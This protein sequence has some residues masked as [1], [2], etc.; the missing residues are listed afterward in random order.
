M[1]VII[2]LLLTILTWRHLPTIPFQGEGFYYF[3]KITN[4][5]ILPQD[6]L[7]QLIFYVI[8][9]I[10][11][12]RLDL[13]MYLLFIVMLV[14]DAALYVLIRVVTEN[15]LTAFVV[16][17]LFSLSYVGNYDMYSSG[18]YQYFVQRAVILLPQLLS[19]MFLIIFFLH[20]FQMRYYRL[21]LALYLLAIGMGFF[22]TWFLPPFLFYPCFYILLNLRRF[23]QIFLKIIWV[24]LPYL[25]GN[26][27]LIKDSLSPYTEEP[28]LTFLLHNPKVIPGLV[29]QL[30]V[31]SL[32]PGI[33]DWSVK[34][35]HLAERTQVVPFLGI[36]TLIF[37][38]CAAMFIWKLKP[39][40]RVL[41]VTS[42]ASI[43]LML[44][45]NLYLN[46][47][48]VLF[49]FNSS[50]YFYFPSVFIA[51]FWGLF[52][53]TLLLFL[54]KNRTYF[55]IAFCAIWLAINNIAI[56]K[57]LKDD[58]W[59][60]RANTDTINYLHLWS[61]DLKAYPSY[62]YLPANL[63][64][65]GASFVFRYFSHPDGKFRL[66]GFDELD[67]PALAKEKVDPNRLY[68]LNL[69]IKDEQVFD[70]TEESRRALRGLE[71]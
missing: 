51:I 32:P 10:F 70:K 27:L 11:N 31:I 7:A 46:S 71:R 34:S 2:L 45:F 20:N 4:K 28:F 43:V 47:A 9:P 38:L 33:Y 58:E 48:N 66:Q 64:T 59:R 37:Y 14:I 63:G 23:K 6:T 57:N 21:S 69:S 1:S 56:Q 39:S 15:R 16:T 52:L 19:L 62:V 55:L 61:R 65:Y 8:P 49:S 50:R 29:Q 36:L 25:A 42:I 40:W 13:Y 44:L 3:E 12:D 5:V 26:I 53:T 68:V 60:N 17:L 22:G 24:P 54:E 30:I 41:M 18:G 35:L 67:L